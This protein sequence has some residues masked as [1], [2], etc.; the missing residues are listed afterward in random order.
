LFGR[1]EERP[2][3]SDFPIK[4][5][6]KKRTVPPPREDDWKGFIH[7]PN[8]R[9]MNGFP[10]RRGAWDETRRTSDETLHYQGG[11]AANLGQIQGRRVFYD[12]PG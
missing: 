3:P 10:V 7:D 11:R 9:I 12:P 8:F 6:E 5:T 2:R 1:P 4:T